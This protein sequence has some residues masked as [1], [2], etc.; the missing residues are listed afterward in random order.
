VGGQLVALHGIEQGRATPR[1]SADLDVL[2]DVRADR[3][4][5]RCIVSFLESN[6]FQPDPGPG[7]VVHR[8]VRTCGGHVIKIDVLAPDNLGAR[9]DLTTTPPG[10][11]LEVPAGSQ[12]LKRAELVTVTIAGRTS[13]VPRPSL[14]GAI[15][16]KVAAV[17]LPGDPERHL[18]DLAFLLSLIADPRVA[19]ADLSAKER[20][21]LR[22]CPLADLEHPAW[23]VLGQPHRAAGQAAMRLLTV[24]AEPDGSSRNALG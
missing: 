4:A 16:G 15:I 13:V 18:T 14:I 2:A 5:L 11:T 7:D 12:A 8:Y 3:A 21:R 19:R 20:G 10:R 9:A 1:P 6:G 24:P 22:S 17:S 23:R